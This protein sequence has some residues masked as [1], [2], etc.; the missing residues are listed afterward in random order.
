MWSSSYKCLRVCVCVCV[1]T[2]TWGENRGLSIGLDTL[3]WL[4]GCLE[5]EGSVDTETGFELLDEEL[6]FLE[7]FAVVF[8][9]DVDGVAGDHGN[10][11]V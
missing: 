5:G 8:F 3:D 6:V 9:H 10:D 2:V 11:L 7:L 1:K 4:V